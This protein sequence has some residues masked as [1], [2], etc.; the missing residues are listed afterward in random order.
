MGKYDA[1]KK[2][3]RSKSRQRDDDLERSYAALYGSKKKKKKNS[4]A[5]SIALCVLAVVLILGLVFAAGK[6][7]SGGNANTVPAGLTAAGVN[8]GGLSRADAAAALH[9]ATDTTYSRTPMEV[10]VGE[11]VYTLSP[12]VSGSLLDVDALLDKAMTLPAGDAQI[13][14]ILPYLDLDTAAIRS[15]VADLE[16]RYPSNFVPAQV[17]DHAGDHRRKHGSADNYRD[18]G[19]QWRVPGRVV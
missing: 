6:L 3:T 17:D 13:M 18:R 7:F 11:D 10:H 1:K 14:D 4:N 5:L 9:E 16:A 12:A 19:P 2:T 8:I 15:F